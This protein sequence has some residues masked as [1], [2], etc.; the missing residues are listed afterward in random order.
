MYNNKKSLLSFY[1]MYS[2]LYTPENKSYKERLKELR[3]ISLEKRRLRRILL[4]S[5]AT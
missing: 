1:Y 4:L 3:L 2:M 5:T